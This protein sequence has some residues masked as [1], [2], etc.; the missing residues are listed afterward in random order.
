DA[1]GKPTNVASK[2]EQQLAGFHDQ[3]RLNFLNP[4]SF[5]YIK[6]R[7]NVAG[8]QSH[9]FRSMPREPAASDKE[10]WAV[11]RLELVS[12]LK[13]DHPVVYSSDHL[14]RMDDLKGAP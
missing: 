12:L 14:P 13:H 6:D 8:F 4:S 7:N 9:Q 5:G 11:I 3:G 2:L 1:G 10:K